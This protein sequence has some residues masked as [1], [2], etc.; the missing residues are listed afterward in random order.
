MQLTNTRPS[1]TAAIAI[2]VASLTIGMTTPTSATP[3]AHHPTVRVVVR[4]VTASGHA[5]PGYT[6]TQSHYA[7]SCSPAAPSPVSISRNVETCSPSAAYAVACWKAAKRKHALCLPNPRQKKLR[8]EPLTGKFAATA[9]VPART[10]SPFAVVLSDG[11]TCNI[12]I[13][14]T[15]GILTSHPNFYAT[16]YCTSGD[17]IWAKGNAAHSGV[18]EAHATWQV[19]TASGAGGNA[20]LV[21]RQVRR[22]YFVATA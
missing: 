10:R 22:A 14:G 3:A 2:T 6:V 9:A 12:R 18:N 11:A 5:V 4:P 8:L 17:A 1:V 20:K 13:G 19:R 15:G 16:Y 21:T 7:I